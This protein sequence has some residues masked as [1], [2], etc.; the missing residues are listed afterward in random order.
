MN[1]TG[2]ILA[3]GKSSRMGQDKGLMQFNGQSFIEHAVQIV[4]DICDNVIIIA[5]QNGYERLSIPVYAD[6]IK[7][8]GPAAGIYTGLHYSK[9]QYNLVVGCDMPFLSSEFLGYLL[10]QIDE[11]ADA[12]VPEYENKS[13]PLCAVYSKGCLYQFE[14]SIQNGQLK[15]REIIGQLHT[16][17]VVI[18]KTAGFYS[19]NLFTNINTHKELETIKNINCK[20]FKNYS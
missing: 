20:L 14:Q 9:T 13:Q 11:K 2:I 10:S 7:D 6:I 15:M 12:I 16:K 5:N 3:G 4:K 1:I 18:D 8:K 17:H 19:P